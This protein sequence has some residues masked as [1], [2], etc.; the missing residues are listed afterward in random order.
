MKIIV[1]VLVLVWGLT[2]AQSYRVLY[3]DELE[4][5]PATITV[6]QG[7]NTLITAH[8]HVEVVTLGR[9]ELLT[10]TR[11]S[12]S[13]IQLNTQAS[14]GVFG[15][16]LVAGGRVQQF[17]VRIGGSLHNRTYAIQAARAAGVIP[18]TLGPVAPAPAPRTAVPAPAPAA[19][20]AATAPAPATPPPT[21]APAPTPVGDW[22]VARV[23]GAPTVSGGGVFVISFSLE[24]T[25]E[26]R[27]NADVARLVIR[28][29]SQERNYTLSRLPTSAL[30]EPGAVQAGSIL[31]QDVATGQIELEWTL[32]EMGENPRTVVLR[33]TLNVAAA[34]SNK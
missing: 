28:Q 3:S 2:F 7:F 31:V 25:S 23:S 22:L 9:P 10:V 13:I 1:A 18:V 30:I 8:D 14:D 33:R 21:A 27:V 15:M 6:V 17:T 16:T 11:I 26:R 12:N 32:T 19:P 24:N 29:G 20:P 34:Q 4:R 5:V